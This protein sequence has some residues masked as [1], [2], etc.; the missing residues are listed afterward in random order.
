M[1]QMENIVF[2][3]A[4]TI[5]NKIRYERYELK[6]EDLKFLNGMGEITYS[7]LSNWLNSLCEDFL[8]GNIEKP[9]ITFIFN[10]ITVVDNIE[11]VASL[12]G[13]KSTR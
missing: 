3:K 7:H 4:V 13:V 8:L 9:D 10:E 6:S 2:E 12:C 5:E 1:T 11:A